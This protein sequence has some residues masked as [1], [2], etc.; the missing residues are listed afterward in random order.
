MRE[1]NFKY[2]YKVLRNKGIFKKDDILIKSQVENT[3]Y[4]EDL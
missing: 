3:I 2:K 4:I 1:E